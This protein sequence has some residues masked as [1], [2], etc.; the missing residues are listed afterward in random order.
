MY[1]LSEALES[2]EYHAPGCRV[3]R[4]EVVRLPV[5][6]DHPQLDTTGDLEL[7]PLGEEGPEWFSPYRCAFREEFAYG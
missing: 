7:F 1:Y 4:H 6:R 2:G 5:A 3:R